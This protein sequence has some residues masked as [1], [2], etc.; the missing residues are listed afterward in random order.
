MQQLNN[1]DVI[2]LITI[3][4]SA[5]IALSRGL[6]KEVLSIIGWVLGTLAIIYL[7]PLLNPLASKYIDSGFMSA[8]VSAL[9]ILIVFLL[10]WTFSTS[11]LVRDIRQ[12][13]MSTVDR[14]LG[15]FFGVARAFLL[16]VLVYIMVS[17]IIPEDKQP[18][19]LKD[20]KY[21]QLAGK[22]AKPIEGLIPEA[23]LDGIRKKA[24]EINAEKEKDPKS[25]DD[26]SDE[27]TTTATVKTGDGPK[28]EIKIQTDDAQQLFDKLTQPKVKR[29]P[30]T[31][32]KGKISEQI[33]DGYNQNERDNLSRLIENTANK[34][35]E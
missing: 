14:V 35:E 28:V 13:K 31:A 5:L 12:S 29:T 27:K 22:F 30:P 24:Q 32:P 11:G 25:K 34:T 1:I 17:W 16:V 19:M 2:I 33:Q 7:L 10:I 21:Y 18:P 26:Q 4:I 3:G 20:S 6:I 15:L 23:T 8:V 9:A